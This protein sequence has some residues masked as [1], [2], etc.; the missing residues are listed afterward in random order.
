MICVDAWFR[1]QMDLFALKVDRALI[2]RSTKARSSGRPEISNLGTG[3]RLVDDDVFGNWWM[4]NCCVRMGIILG[5][6]TVDR[7]GQG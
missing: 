6:S 1:M 7:V 5:N 3:Q 2:F 4:L